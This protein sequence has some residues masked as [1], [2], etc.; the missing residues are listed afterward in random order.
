MLA[1]SLP[2]LF[3]LAP[4]FMNTSFFTLPFV[5]ETAVNFILYFSTYSAVFSLPLILVDVTFHYLISI[6]LSF[7]ILFSSSISLPMTVYLFGCPKTELRLNSVALVCERNMPTER[8][9][10]VREVVP[11]FGDRGCRVVIATDSHVR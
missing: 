2:C 7:T 9:P 11:T 5:L 10:L 3:L 6:L 8:P 4:L 1:P